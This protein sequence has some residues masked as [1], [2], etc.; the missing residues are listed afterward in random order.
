MSSDQLI[1]N[2]STWSS[3]IYGVILP[4]K[5]TIEHSGISVYLIINTYRVITTTPLA[6]YNLTSHIIY[7]LFSDT[8]HVH[9]QRGNHNT[10]GVD[11]KNDMNVSTQTVYHWK[12]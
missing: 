10:K 12:H 1:L 3:L 6:T 2:L 4:Q 8:V 11:V 7:A 9:W 5:K